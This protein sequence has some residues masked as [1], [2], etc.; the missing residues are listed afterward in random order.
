MSVQALPIMAWLALGNLVYVVIGFFIGSAI[1]HITKPAPALRSILRL[2]PSIGHANSIPIML[3]TMICD[4]SQGF[5]S[6]DS[7]MAQGYVGFY[8]VMHSR[9]IWG[10]GLSVVKKE[11]DVEPDAAISDTSPESAT[12]Q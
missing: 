8:L 11:K 2:A 9:T 10:I 5:E 6:G 4:E 1:I 12:S 3:V 7:A